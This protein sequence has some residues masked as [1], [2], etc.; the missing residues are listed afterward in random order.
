MEKNNMLN[1]LEKTAVMATE[2]IKERLKKFNNVK[3]F[4]RVDAINTVDYYFS[5]QNKY[6]DKEHFI[7][8]LESLFLVYL[9]FFNEHYPDEV[10]DDLEHPVQKVIT[11]IEENF[12]LLL[13]HGEPENNAVFRRKE[14]MRIV[15]KNPYTVKMVE[16]KEIL[17][18]LINLK[19]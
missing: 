10:L 18:G 6:T 19:E 12:D 15:G 7:I 8:Y 2:S 16:I 5:L 4:L 11:Y 13:Y 14:K 3:T 1:S 9:D 17:R